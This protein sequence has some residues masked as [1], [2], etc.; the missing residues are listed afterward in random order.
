MRS[1]YTLFWLLTPIIGVVG[2][3]KARR[4]EGWQRLL[5]LWSGAIV[6][7]SFVVTMLFVALWVTSI[8]SFGLGYAEVDALLKAVWPVALNSMT[9]FGMI[10][11]IS[12]FI[13]SLSRLWRADKKRDGIDE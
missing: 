5:M 10:C 4:L 1:L 13:P 9:A 7:C 6:V 8:V 2:M 3:V 12:I 11:L